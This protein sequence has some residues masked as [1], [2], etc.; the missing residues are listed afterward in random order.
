MSQYD[1]ET[2][3]KIEINALQYQTKF[4]FSM[5]YVLFSLQQVRRTWNKFLKF[6]E[7]HLHKGSTPKLIGYYNLLTSL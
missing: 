1:T 3:L 6:T 4:I 2:N 7:A 5:I